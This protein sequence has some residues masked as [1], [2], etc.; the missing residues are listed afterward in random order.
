MGV[1][2]GFLSRAYKICTE[3]YLQ[4]KV[5][6]LTDIFKENGYNRNMLININ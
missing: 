2:N 3:K 1:F 4:N 5:D 6:F